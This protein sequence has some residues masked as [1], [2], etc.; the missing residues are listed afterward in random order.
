MKKQKKIESYEEITKR[1]LN[2]ISDEDEIFDETQTGPQEETTFDSYKFDLNK[3]KEYK[4]KM[5]RSK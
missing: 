2:E 1:V 5:K 3:F 4:N